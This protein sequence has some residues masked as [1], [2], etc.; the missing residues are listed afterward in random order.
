MLLTLHLLPP[1]REGGQ[2][3]KKG[4]DRRKQKGELAVMRRVRN[5]RDEGG[6]K[7]KVWRERRT[8]KMRRGNERNEKKMERNK[9]ARKGYRTRAKD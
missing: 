9:N 5:R 6:L 1:P 4:G 7:E 3:A 8:G 2:G